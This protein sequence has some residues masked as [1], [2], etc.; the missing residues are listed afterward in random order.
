MRSD[1]TTVLRLRV[2][3][4]PGV[5]SH[6]CGLFARRGYN[7]E[8]VLCLA[9]DD[10]AC[11]AVLL[12]VAADQRLDQ[13]VAQLGKLEDVLDVHEDAVARSAFDTAARWAVA[14]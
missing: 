9:L 14:S 1:E 7:V 10:R 11:S 4:H 6:V 3:N 8:G 5:L 13:V 2:R 12:L